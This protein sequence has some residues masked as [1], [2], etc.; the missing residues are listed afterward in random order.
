MVTPWQWIEE[1]VA[2]TGMD[3]ASGWTGC[4]LMLLHSKGLCRL[5]GQGK[6]SLSPFDRERMGLS[7]AT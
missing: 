3:A 4:G 2:I 5:C 7:K 1:E 6:A